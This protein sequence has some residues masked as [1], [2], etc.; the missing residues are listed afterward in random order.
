MSEHPISVGDHDKSRERPATSPEPRHAGGAPRNKMPGDQPPNDHPTHL[1]L[2]TPIEEQTRKEPILATATDPRRDILTPAEV[3][4]WLGVTV[5]T[6]NTWRYTR[7]GPS[8]TKLGRM[9]R[10][11]REQ[12]EK[13]ISAG[14]VQTAA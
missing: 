10:Y 13:F 3:A 8:F 4:D 14:R 9:I 6:L 12:V 1:P 7:T 2:H 11:E 5:Q